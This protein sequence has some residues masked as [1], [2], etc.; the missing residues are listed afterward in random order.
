[1]DVQIFQKHFDNLAMIHLQWRNKNY[2]PRKMYLGD[3]EKLKR[4]LWLQNGW[5]SGEMFPSPE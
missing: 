2:L 1:M 4:K 5:F 3:I